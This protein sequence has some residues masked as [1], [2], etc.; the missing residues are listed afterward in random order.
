MIHFYTGDLL[1]HRVLPFSWPY[2]LSETMSKLHSLDDSN[3]TSVGHFD[4]SNVFYGPLYIWIW[5]SNE[6]ILLRIMTFFSF[7]KWRIMTNQP[8]QWTIQIDEWP[9]VP[10]L[11]L[12]VCFIGCWQVKLFFFFKEIFASISLEEHFYSCFLPVLDSFLVQVTSA[13]YLFIF[14]M[15]TWLKSTTSWFWKWAPS[16][17]WKDLCDWKGL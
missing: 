1:F 2:F 8:H 6:N 15:V 3:N 4:R 7:P 11:V 12:I 16:T 14:W 17:F 10:L 5:K 9:F 13:T